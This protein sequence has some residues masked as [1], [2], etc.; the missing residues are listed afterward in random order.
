MVWHLTSLPRSVAVNFCNNINKIQVIYWYLF[1]GFVVCSVSIP[2][3]VILPCMYT[4]IANKCMYYYRDISLPIYSSLI[5]YPNL[6]V[7]VLSDMI[8][9][10]CRDHMWVTGW[11]S[12]WKDSVLQWWIP[13]W[14]CSHLHL[15]PRFQPHWQWQETVPGTWRVELTVTT[16]H[17]Y[18]WLSSTVCACY[19]HL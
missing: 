2:F 11:S 4:I 7:I 14:L 19:A 9:Y 5:L 6:G 1:V 3:M 15:W 10:Q 17:W 8:L 18:V 12:Q 13:V 16:V